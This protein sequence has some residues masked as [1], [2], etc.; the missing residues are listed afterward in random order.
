MLVKNILERIP[1]MDFLLRKTFLTKRFSFQGMF[2]LT[3]L[4]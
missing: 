4:L 3:E 1:K 2:E